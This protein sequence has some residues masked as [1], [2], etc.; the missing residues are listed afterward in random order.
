M[1][2]PIIVQ[3][4]PYILELEPKNYSYCTCG[5]SQN[6]PFCDGSHKGTSFAPIRMKITET[7]KVALCGCKQSGNGAF[8]DGS[9]SKLK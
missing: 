7:K 5:K 2:K 3:K 4:K 6:D 9:H 8:C 1:E